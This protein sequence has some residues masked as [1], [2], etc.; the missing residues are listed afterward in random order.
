MV[1]DSGVERLVTRKVI[2]APNLDAN[3]L[4][5]RL[6]DIQYQLSNA[7]SGAPFTDKFGRRVLTGPA[8][9]P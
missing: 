3:S 2:A 5:S 7:H 6:A 4:R 9:L 1:I 8:C